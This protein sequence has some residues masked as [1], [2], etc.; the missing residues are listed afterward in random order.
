MDKF[1]TPFI[2]GNET[3]LLTT[4]NP[5]QDFACVLANS[6]LFFG[7]IQAGNALSKSFSQPHVFMILATTILY[8]DLKTAAIQ[9]EI[10]GYNSSR[11]KRAPVPAIFGMNFQAFS[12]AEKDLAN[13]GIAADGT[14]SQELIDAL[15][16]IDAKVGQMIDSLKSKGLYNSTLV[17]LTA[18]HGQ[19]PRLGKATLIKDDVFTNV[20]QQA[21]IEVAQATQ[22]DVA[23][24]WLKDHKQTE[25]ASRLLQALK[26]ASPDVGVDKVLA[27][28]DLAAENLG[29][30]FKDR[31]PD[32]IVKLKPGFVLV[33]NPATSNKRAEHGGFSPDDTQVALIVGGGRV[34]NN[35][36]ST[37]VTE[38]VTTAQIAVTALKSLFGQ[39][40]IKSYT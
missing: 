27:G 12:V 24:L 33:G 34:P 13:G 21:N 38:K 16:H 25:A 29:N 14:P 31:T 28:K 22:D 2:D 18:K 37:S 4:K 6:Q 19:N 26:N 17:V 20:L 9:N 1:N 7:L 3:I 8:D 23:L 32:L 10:A 35:L 30:D 5:I 15:S 11:T 39:G 36:R 40:K